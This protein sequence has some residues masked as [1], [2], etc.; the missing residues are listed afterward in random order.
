MYK[1]IIFDIDG[2][3]LDT[4]AT[5]M[6]SLKRVCKEFLDVEYTSEQLRFTLGMPGVMALE[7]LGIPK[8]KCDDGLLKWE[9]YFEENVS[10]IKHFDGI[11]ELLEVLDSKG[12][13]MGI[14]TSKTRHEYNVDFV[15]FGL[16]SFFNTVICVEDSETHKPDKG[17]MVEYLKR[18][19]ITPEEAIYI[20]DAIHDYN[21][22]TAAGVDFI[23]ALWGCRDDSMINCANKCKHPIDVLK[24]VENK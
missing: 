4:E 22:A 13:Q 24:I 11:K 6:V 21:C 17:P 1:H 7:K 16:E 19:N 3:L 8:D 12:Y 10:L 2:T 23:L 5:V 18:N 9:K 20:G 14:I 15:P